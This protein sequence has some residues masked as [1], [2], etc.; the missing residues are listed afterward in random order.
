VAFERV[1]VYKEKTLHLCH[2]IQKQQFFSKKK[3][4]KPAVSLL[5]AFESF[6]YGLLITETLFLAWWV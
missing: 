1:R 4:K 2:P 3:K 6:W 5:M